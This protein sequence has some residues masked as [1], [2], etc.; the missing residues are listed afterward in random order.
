MAI[1]FADTGYYL[2]LLNR[3]DA[4]ASRALAFDRTRTDV[5]FVTSD[6]VLTE[7]LAYVSGRGRDARASAIAL[8][9]A[10]RIDDR[11]QI[12]RQTPE[13]FDAAF[14]LYRRRGDK[15]YSLT[16]CMSMNICREMD[17]E[18]VLT[19]DRHFAQEGFTV[20]L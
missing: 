6:S 2:A 7:I 1:A 12:I 15:G 11:V 14:E 4:L 19:H 16:D 17:I 20:L 10:L 3:R 5:A 8:I 18:D 13:I 9:D